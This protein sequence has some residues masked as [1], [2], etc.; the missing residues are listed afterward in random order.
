MKS[1]LS[2]DSIDKVEGHIENVITFANLRSQ[3]ISSQ[4]LLKWSIVIDIIEEY[5]QYLITNDKQFD[6]IHFS[7]CSSLWFGSHCQYTFGLQDSIQSFGDFVVSS[8]NTRKNFQRKLKINSCYPFLSEC[9][10]GPVPMCLDWREICDGK[11]DC[12]GENS[13]IDERYCEQMEMTDCN[14]NEF[15]C[16]NGA[17]CIPFEFY[18]DHRL[19]Q[20]C[21]DG[22]DEIEDR[23]LS[24][25]DESSSDVPNCLSTITFQCEE[26]N[27]P[28][29]LSFSCGDGQCVRFTPYVGLFDETP[30]QCIQRYS[31][32]LQI[33]DQFY[34]RNLSNDC[35]QL[36]ICKIDLYYYNYIGM[37]SEC[38]STNE[39]CSMKYLKIPLHSVV[40]YIQLVFITEKLLDSNSNDFIWTDCICVDPKQCLDLSNKRKKFEMDNLN[41]YPIEEMIPFEVTNSF[42][43]NLIFENDVIDR[44]LLIAN[45][46]LHRYSFVIYQIDTFRNI[47]YL[48]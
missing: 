30:C 11:I 18:R 27:C 45:Q 43:L 20:D 33:I 44:C 2:D 31:F 12:I 13:G 14:E 6:E 38:Q 28:Q 26:K 19:S 5:A 29:K 22:S 24:N 3:R 34:R 17:Q 8:M 4:E 42:Y 23:I 40:H 47:V 15:R 25:Y 37:S 16:W 39:K 1:I 41:C 9:N 48:L 10:R 46:I 7:N 35:Y 36:L 32:Y 21:L